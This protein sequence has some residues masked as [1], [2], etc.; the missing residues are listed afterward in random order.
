MKRVRNNNIFLRFICKGLWML[1][2]LLFI[3][4]CAPNMAPTEVSAQPKT[5]EVPS[6]PS[7]VVEPYYYYLDGE[8]V[9]LIPS[10][11]WISVLYT[12][13]DPSERTGILQ[14]YANLLGPLDQ[15]RSIPMPEISLLPLPVG[16]TLQEFTE[17]LA[18]MRNDRTSFSQANPLFDAVGVEMVISDEF[19][20]TF[21]DETSQSE[22]DEI[23]SAHSVEL[24][25]PV[26]GQENTYILRVAEGAVLDTLSMANLYQENGIV[27]HAAPNFI[28]LK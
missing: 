9:P 19:I 10:L 7:M 13:A 25:K 8:R 20:A 17:L 4:G 16:I 14:K 11:E 15:V 24:I 3:A 23:N 5:P 18:A 26:S 6:Q 21:P 27:L 2:G 12:T 22:I 28:R 1:S